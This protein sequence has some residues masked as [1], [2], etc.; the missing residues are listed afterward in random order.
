MRILIVDDDYVS[1]SKLKA[2]LSGYGDC[3]AVPNGTLAL[4]MVKLAQEEGVPY[5]LIT[6]D[7][8]MPGEKGQE[9]VEKIRL[10]EET[11]NLSAHPSEIK[12]LMVTVISQP[13]DIMTSFRKGCEGYLIKPVTPQSLKESLAKIG[14]TL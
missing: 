12:I 14:F 7:I 1:R 2:M 11:T 8:D 5:N 6:M 4:D 9:V 3:D 10:W 13:R